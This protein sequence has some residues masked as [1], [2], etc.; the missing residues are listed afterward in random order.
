MVISTLNKTLSNYA[1]AE[2]ES[3]AAANSVGTD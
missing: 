1:D 3:T 2:A